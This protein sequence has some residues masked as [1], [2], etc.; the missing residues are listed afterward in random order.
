MKVPI[1]LVATALAAGLVGSVSSDASTSFGLLPGFHRV[2][3]G[4]YGGTVWVGHIPN[5]EAGWDRRN[6]AVYL[7][8]SFS[9]TTPYAT[10]YLLHGLSGSPSSYYDGLRLADVADRQIAFGAAAPFI[11]VMPVG[12]CL[13][14]NRNKDEWTGR[15]EDYVVRDVVP[16]VDHRLPTVRSARARAIAGLSAGGFG[17]IDIGLRH[18][19]TFGTLESWG[20]YYHPFRDGS[21]ASATPAEMRAHDPTVLVRREARVLR[22][23]RVRFFLSTGFNHGGVFRA[24]TLA[25]A[26]ELRQLQLR[27]ELWQLPLSQYG[28]FWTAQ[29]PDALAY[30]A[31]PNGTAP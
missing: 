5:R 26:R 19:E 4:P 24:W 10:V 31:P 28:H 6:S 8:P 14:C 27:H 11:A 3:T 20:G 17:A 30:A 23:R 18:P 12:G 2:S 25:F 16:W 9:P 21:L 13:D 7:P 22:A 1:A 15:W 29:L